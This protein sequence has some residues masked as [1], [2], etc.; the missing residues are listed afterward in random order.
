MSSDSN[1]LVLDPFCGSGSTGKAAWI[2]NRRFI[3]IEKNEEYFKRAEERMKK[4]MLQKK[5]TEF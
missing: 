3:L 1:E 5:I 4:L 2:S